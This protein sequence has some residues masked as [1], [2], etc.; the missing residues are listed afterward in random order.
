M[1]LLNPYDNLTTVILFKESPAIA[2]VVVFALAAIVAG[3]VAGLRKYID[4]KLWVMS[5]IALVGTMTCL[6]LFLPMGGAPQR[7]VYAHLAFAIAFMWC[8]GGRLF[9]EAGKQENPNRLWW[10][11]VLLGFLN[12]VYLVFAIGAIRETALAAQQG[13]VLAVKLADEIRG[14]SRDKPILI[15]AYPNAFRQRAILGHPDWTVGY[16]LNGK[17]GRE[18]RVFGG[19]AVVHYGDVAHAPVVNVRRTGP[20]TFEVSTAEQRTVLLL[21]DFWYRNAYS[22]QYLE[23]AFGRVQVEEVGPYHR[24][25][26]VSV[27]IDESWAA[28]GA[29]FYYFSA[30][31]VCEVD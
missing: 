26:K 16:Q 11:A 24:A 30:G 5:G 22:G 28:A 8:V 2:A 25:M 19:A 18:Q 21:K 20:A 9:Q 14:T 12:V 7:A 15:L 31:E 1:P 4:K 13:R 29:R 23:R 6:Q 17:F 27:H 3:M 10:L